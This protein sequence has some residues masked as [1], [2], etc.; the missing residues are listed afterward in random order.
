MCRQFIEK[1]RDDPKFLFMLAVQIGTVLF[2]VFKIYFGMDYQVQANT[3]WLE[4]N[5]DIG[6]RVFQLEKQAD[7]L[8]T[9]PQRIARIEATND[10]MIKQ[11]DRIELYL[12]KGKGEVG[13]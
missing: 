8:R 11:L 13:P 2:C 7:D 4:T 9:I 6:T 3:K 12:I 1:I 10:S 5:K